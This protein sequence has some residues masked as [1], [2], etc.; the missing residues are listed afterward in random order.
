VLGLEAIAAHNGWAMA[1]IGALIVFTGLILLSLAV[2]QIHNVLQ[3]WDKRGLSLRPKKSGG[4][5]GETGAEP[6]KIALSPEAKIAA[7][8][9]KLL[10]E[11]IGEPFTLPKLLEL[12]Q[13]AGLARSHGKVDELV[14]A[15]L[16]VPDGKGAF[17]WNQPVFETN[18]INS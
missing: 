8:Q 13:K 4:Q 11:R 16:I 18:V 3:F 6:S 12:S 7:K 14:D 17:S 5:E 1:L 10:I 2:S 9:V 15:G